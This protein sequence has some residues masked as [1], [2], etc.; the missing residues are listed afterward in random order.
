MLFGFVSPEASQAHRFAFAHQ[1]K[2]WG[3]INDSNEKS[4]IHAVDAW[5]IQEG[6]RDIVVAV[7]DTGLDA[8]HRDLA[9]NVWHDPHSSSTYGW[10]FVTDHSNPND[11]HGHGTHIAGIIGAIADPQNGVSGVAHHVSIMP[12]KYYS[13][14]N[15]G[16]VNLRNTVS[17]INYAVEHGARIINY[18]GGGPEFSEDEY[19]AIKKAEARGVLFVAAA[20]NEHQDTD[21]SENYYYPAAYHLSNIISVAATDIRNNLLPSSNWGKKKVDIAAPG[22]NI[23]STLPGGRYGYMTGTSQ[24]TAFV[25]GVAALLLSQDPSLTPSEIKEIIMDSADS[26]AGLKDKLASGGR[27]NAYHALTLLEDRYP[28]HVRPSVIASASRSRSRPALARTSASILNVNVNVNVNE[29]ADS[30]GS[31]TRSD[32][33]FKIWE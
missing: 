15:P 8:T 13:D 16:S 20:G 33:L 3:L 10:N 19:L 1:L 30:N 25:T 22:E 6:S 17:A 29:N 26:I 14:A 31:A 7:I 2:N 5:R 21:L 27:V 32:S 23:Y 11:D 28:E 4:D 12:V 9:K 18:S 24:A